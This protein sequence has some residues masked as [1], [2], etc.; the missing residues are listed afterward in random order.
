M[1]LS[2]SAS[3]SAG[4]GSDSEW[5]LGEVGSR[6]SRGFSSAGLPLVVVAAVAEGVAIGLEREMAERD[7]HWGSTIECYS[8]SLGDTSSY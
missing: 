7:K 5:G 1:D 4:I 6:V 2:S 8:F 3:L